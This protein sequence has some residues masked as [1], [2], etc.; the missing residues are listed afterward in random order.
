MRYGSHSWPDPCADMPCTCS[1]TT[2]NSTSSLRAT[3]DWI[4]SSCLKRFFC[5]YFSEL[6]CGNFMSFDLGLDAYN[7]QIKVQSMKV[8]R[9]EADR[10]LQCLVSSIYLIKSIIVQYLVLWFVL[11][12]IW[13]IIVFPG[14]RL[15]WCW[16]APY[17]G[18]KGIISWWF[19][20]QNVNWANKPSR[21][22]LKKIQK[23][24]Q[25]NYCHQDNF[26]PYLHNAPHLACAY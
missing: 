22:V 20:S 15:S 7:A 5:L 2:T 4:L 16:P 18:I 12:L 17:K 25:R 9:L 1:P 23:N 26:L 8:Q 3:S 11:L 19:S 21:T 24:I 14:A 6:N 13:P 10:P